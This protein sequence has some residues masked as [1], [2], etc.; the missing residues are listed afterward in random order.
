MP[1]VLSRFI[2]F[3]N[4]YTMF[5]PYIYLKKKLNPTATAVTTVLQEVFTF[6]REDSTTVVALQCVCGLHSV[7]GSHLMAARGWAAVI[8]INVLQEDS[9]TFGREDSTTRC[10]SA[11]DVERQSAADGSHPQ[12]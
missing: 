2:Y 4:S 8:I 6:G 11:A 9:A 12:S 3:H 10:R 5:S 1:C 7:A